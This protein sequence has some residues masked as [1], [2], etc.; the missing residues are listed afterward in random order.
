M[1]S[2]HR[3]PLAALVTTTLL[4]LTG[5]SKP[6]L[7]YRNA[8]IPDGLI[9]A[10]DANEPFTG[11]V[12][13]V[14]DSFLLS[15]AKGYSKFMQEAGGNSYAVAR[16][17][18]AAIG[19]D[20]PTFLCDVSV[21]KGYVDGKA[22]CYLPR[23]DTKLIEAHFSGGQ[24]SGKFVYYNSDKPGQKLIEGIFNDGQPDGT[25]KIYSESTGKLV[26]KVGWSNGTHDGDFA[27]Y[28][29][30]N[31]KVVLEGT[32]A[33]GKREG[34]WKQYTSDGAQLIARLRYR[35]GQYDGVAEGFDA[36]TGE[37][38]A[39]IDKWVDGKINGEHKT[40]DKSG[41]LLTDEVYVDGKKVA[42]KNAPNASGA[43]NESQQGRV[44]KSLAEPV[45]NDTPS[46]PVPP[47]V[48]QSMPGSAT[49][50]SSAPSVSL[51]ACVQ[52][53]TK[54]NHEAAVKAG[55]DDAVTADQVG[56]WEVWCRQG[57]QAPAG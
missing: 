22:T 18:Q 3:I 50:V 37:R 11:T 19:N 23:V 29:A 41:L 53:W 31:G 48:R 36:E 54:A 42:D 10:T 1:K 4:A 32:F 5:C 9:Y 39:L 20:S 13:H 46:A 15:D 51:D 45:S 40:W 25:E 16:L 55:V 47:S 17:I 21:R 38:T 35:E 12:T 28:N 34:A 27:S 57:K 7:D 26:E 2:P 24:L 52:R 6:V 30:T 33:E 49:A 8:E 43:D 56:E 44:D 14:P